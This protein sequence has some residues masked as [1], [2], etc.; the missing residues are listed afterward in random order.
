[1]LLHLFEKLHLASKARDFLFD[2]VRFGVSNVTL[3]TICAVE[4][5]EV[6]RD[7]GVNL[8]HSL[9]D[10]SHREVLVPIVD[11]LESA[12]IDRNNSKTE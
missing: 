7:A 4:R 6:T 9:A 3:L 12:A 2:P 11:G 8:F 10:L 1:M 5:G